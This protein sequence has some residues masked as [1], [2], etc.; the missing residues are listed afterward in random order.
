MIKNP[1]W[2][3][4]NQLYACQL[5][6]SQ[7]HEIFI[8]RVPLRIFRREPNHIQRR[9]KILEDILKIFKV[10]KKKIMPRMDCR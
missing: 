10:R 8:L 1:N 4:E 5:F 2:Q 9:L 6:L 3:V 7:M